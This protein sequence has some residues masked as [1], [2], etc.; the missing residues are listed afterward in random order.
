MCGS[1]QH[2]NDGYSILR[3]RL[4]QGSRR[5]YLRWSSFLRAMV[6]AFTCDGYRLYAMCHCLYV[7]GAVAVMK[8]AVAIMKCSVATM[9]YAVPL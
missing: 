4:S 6:I 5:F 9:K 1:S 3:Y 8:Y 7:K 2:G